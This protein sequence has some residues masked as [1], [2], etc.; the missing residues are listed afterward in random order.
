MILVYHL[1]VHYKELFTV[2]PEEIL[3]AAEY[4]NITIAVKNAV[5]KK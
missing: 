2:I 5:S 4:K 1:M 3:F